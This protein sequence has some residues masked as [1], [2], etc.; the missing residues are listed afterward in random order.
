MGYDVFFVV[1][2]CYG[3]QQYSVDYRISELDR[4][5]LS[6]C[7]MAKTLI[8]SKKDS[9][10]F[11]IIFSEFNDF[12]FKIWRKHFQCNWHIFSGLN[13]NNLMK[14]WLEIKKKIWVVTIVSSNKIV[15][16]LLII[17]ERYFALIEK[18]EFYNLFKR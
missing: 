17:L 11:D 13:R 3:I 2:H 8:S 14:F 5:T 4:S 9:K 15:S 12:I 18:N 7:M 1:F 16:F 6:F 10:K